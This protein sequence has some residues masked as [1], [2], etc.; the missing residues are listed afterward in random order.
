[1]KLTLLLNIYFDTF[2]YYFQA[3]TEPGSSDDPLVEVMDLYEG[4]S[5]ML[6]VTAALELVLQKAKQPPLSFL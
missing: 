3:L 6:S 2:Y 5:E 1:M 4:T